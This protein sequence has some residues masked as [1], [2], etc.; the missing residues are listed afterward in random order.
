MVYRSISLFLF[1]WVSMI[2]ATQCPV[3]VDTFHTSTAE[4]FTFSNW[5]EFQIENVIIA[6]DNSEIYATSKCLISAV[7]NSIIMKMNEHFE[8]NWYKTLEGE[9]THDSLEVTPDTEDLVLIPFRSNRCDIFRLNSTDGSIIL[10]KTF[11]IA[12]R[13]TSIKLSEDGV[14]GYISAIYGLS[15]TIALLRMSDLEVISSFNHTLGSSISYVYGYKTASEDYNV[16]VGAK[17]IL[18]AFHVISLDMTSILLPLNWGKVFGN[19]WLLF[20]P[21]TSLPAIGAIDEVAQIG[22]MLITYDDKPLFFSLNLS[23]GNLVGSFHESSLSQPNVKASIMEMSH[24]SGTLYIFIPHD[25]GFHLFHYYPGT[26]TFGTTLTST[27]LKIYFLTIMNNYVYF[28]GKV[29]SNQNAFITNIAGEGNYDQNPVYNLSNSAVTFSPVG[30]YSLSSDILLIVI[31]LV[32]LGSGAS[33]TPF[34]TTQGSYIQ[35]STNLFSSDVV[36]RGGFEEIYY[37]KENL[38]G[39]VEFNASCSQSGTTAI[40]SSIVAHPD[41]GTFP[42]WVSLNVDNNHLDVNAPSFGASNDYY[43]VFQSVILGENVKKY[44]T[45]S[46]FE[47]AVA[48]CFDCKYESVHM[49]EEWDPGFTLSFDKLFWYHPNVGM[50]PPVPVDENETADNVAQEE[51]ENSVAGVL[52]MVQALLAAVFITSIANSMFFDSSLQGMWSLFNQYQLTLILPL[53]KTFL[54]DE[55]IYF[56]SGMEYLSFSLDFISFKHIGFFNSLHDYLDYDQSDEVYMDIGYDS[57]SYIVNQSGFYIMIVI[58][59]IWN[60]LFLPVYMYYK[61]DEQ[62]IWTSFVKKIGNMLHISLYIRIMF[63][64]FVFNFLLTSHELYKSSNIF[65]KHFISY[66]VAG[67]NMIILFLFL[68]API[69]M[70]IKYSSRVT[71]IKSVKE[72]Y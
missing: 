50:I 71:H 34:V 20:C 37:I 3:D 2:A 4:S 22:Y 52:G 27:T 59:A 28:G 6:G 33:A 25:N 69:V 39:K 7:T 38:S 13:W 68:S 72:L 67:M 16:L 18:G 15:P 60:L 56:I 12:T 19:G 51:I 47:W 40:S 61:L 26:S 11:T 57:G 24:D 53:L 49:W 64:G 9:V 32:T 70:Y 42:A 55:F 23:N 58:L 8:I 14:Y 41:T 63:E 65:H 21:T 36:Y 1:L 45:M 10:Q 5:A 43:F 54:F 44:V 48:N 29:L 66:I 35:S 30:G 46:I 62:S 31:Q 17:S